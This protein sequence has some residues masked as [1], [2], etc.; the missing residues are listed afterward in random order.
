MP[1]CDPSSL[2]RILS[3]G[4]RFPMETGVGRNAV[5][6]THVS[7]VETVC[8]DTEVA[9]VVGVGDKSR[10]TQEQV[11]SREGPGLSQV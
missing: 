1:N 4:T 3:D 10:K 11:E 9:G 8:L 5:L 7:D 6:R 2:H